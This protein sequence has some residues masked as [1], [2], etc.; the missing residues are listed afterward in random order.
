MGKK[1]TVIIQDW[2]WRDSWSGPEAQPSTAHLNEED[3]AAYADARIGDRSGP[4]PDGY[5]TLLGNRVVEADDA[6][7]AAVEAGRPG[8]IVR[9][10]TGYTPA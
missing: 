9:K 7:F 4:V 5:I 6:L 8:I 3:R 2:E 1:H 10:H